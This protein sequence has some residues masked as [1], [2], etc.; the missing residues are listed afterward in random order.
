VSGADY[1]TYT[2]LIAGTTARASDV[3]QRMAAIQSAFAKLPLP[4]KLQ[5]GRATAVTDTGAT[6]ALIVNLDFAPSSYAF[7]LEMTVLVA[8]TNSGPATVN[9]SGLGNKNIVRADGSPLQAGDLTQGR[10]VH[11]VYGGDGQFQVLGAAESVA[12]AAETAAAASAAASASSATTSFNY[13]TQA[14]ASAAAAAGS[15]TAA[16]ASAA[17]ASTVVTGY[18]P[19]SGATMTGA[20]TLAGDPAAPLQ[21]ATKQYVDAI[22]IAAGSFTA[23][24]A[25]ITLSAGQF[26]LTAIATSRILGNVS[27]SSAKPIAL[28]GAQVVAMLP[29]FGISAAGVVPSTGG[30]SGRVLADDGTWTAITS[31]SGNAGTATKL[32]TAR[33]IS[34][35]G[36][37][38]GSATAFDGSSNITIPI[39][40]MD[41]GAATSGVLAVARGGTG[42]TTATGSGSVVLSA[43]PTL[44]GT[45]TAGAINA[46]G[47]VVLNANQKSYYWTDASGSHPFFGC[48]NDN[49]LVLYG[50]DSTGSPR[51]IFSVFMRSNSS[52]FGFAIPAQGQ[53]PAAGNNSQLLATTAY[54]QGELT[55][56]SKARLIVSSVN[57]SFSLNDGHNNSII[58]ITNSGTVTAPNITA[59]TSLILINIGGS[60]WTF[61]C[62]GGVFT[63]GA[64]STVTSV[65]IPAGARCTAIHLGSGVWLLS[66]V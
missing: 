11:L 27:G 21:A 33:T 41:V 25:T 22:A 36:A 57:A 56:Y 46:S 61:S 59:G 35:S 14:A 19:K 40:A 7:G 30:A 23:D 47:D 32:A 1:F 37:V 48:Q 55:S 42:V 45:L 24:G 13:A 20:L 16:A 10:I 49:N 9:V 66:G 64:T 18:V 54:V 60:A 5:Q 50:T 44:T 63:D 53:T 17:A 31:V 65:N 4:D 52:Q 15:A 39:I 43:S 38:T 34:L 26:A 8:N 58:Q 2:N 12:M 28:T 29:F 51:S 3:N 6:N 62:A